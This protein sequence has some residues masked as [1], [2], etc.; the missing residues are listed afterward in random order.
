MDRSV[1]FLPGQLARRKRGDI[2]GEVLSGPMRPRYPLLKRTDRASR[3]G[4]YSYL[5]IHP[6]LTLDRM[7][8]V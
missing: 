5:E 2:M 3:P 6:E 4:L 1:G 8:Y 7:P